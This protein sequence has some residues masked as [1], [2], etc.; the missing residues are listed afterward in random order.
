MNTKTVI[1][2]FLS[3][4]FISVIGSIAATLGYYNGKK[5][6]EKPDHTFKYTFNAETKKW[7]LNKRE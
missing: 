5:S 4:F 7:L 1:M 6:I 2:I 3:A